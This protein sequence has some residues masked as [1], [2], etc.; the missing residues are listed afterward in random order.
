MKINPFEDHPLTP[1]SDAANTG[2]VSLSQVV[3]AIE[4]ALLENKVI[5]DG[6]H[7]RSTETYVALEN[8]LRELKHR[9]MDLPRRNNVSTK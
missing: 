4:E 2:N 7:N 9:F 5:F 1:R 8:T 3:I 6:H